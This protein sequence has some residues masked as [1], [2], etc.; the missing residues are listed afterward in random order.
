MAKQLKLD[1]VGEWSEFKL[2]VVKEYAFEYSKI[3]SKQEYLSHIYI[4]A[5]AGAGV[6][7]SKE[8]GLFIPGSPLNALTVEPDFSEYHFIDI[9][10]SKAALLKEMTSSH[11]NVKIHQGNC[12]EILLNNIIPSIQYGQFKRALCILDPY[13]MQLDWKVI[14]AAGRIGTIDVFINF[15]IADINRNAIR[16]DQSKASDEGLTRLTTFWGD[17]S[18]KE[19][20]YRPGRQQGL[21]ADEIEKI[22]NRELVEAFCD[23]LNMVAGFEYVAEPIDMRNSKNAT[24]YYL[25]FASQ[26]SVA[27]KIVEAIIRKPRAKQSGIAN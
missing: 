16:R 9:D 1:E 27:K 3:L 25:L 22:S 26:K 18:W 17:E 5:F 11:K 10:S 6:H 24:V 15:P 23:R 4:D 21:F 2:A 20:A 13:G 8:T 7:I 12:N 19:I 14:E